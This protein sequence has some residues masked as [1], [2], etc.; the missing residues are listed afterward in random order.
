MI[1]NPNKWDKYLVFSDDFRDIAAATQVICEV[2]T[3]S[4]TGLMVSQFASLLN[5]YWD[6][7]TFTNTAFSLNEKCSIIVTSNE[8]MTQLYFQR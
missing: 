8:G 4:T 5:V 2:G 6:N 7:G 1:K 3:Y